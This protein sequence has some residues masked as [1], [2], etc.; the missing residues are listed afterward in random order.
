[1]SHAVIADPYAGVGMGVSSVDDTFENEDPLSLKIYL[2]YRIIP[3]IAVEA[4]YTMYASDSYLDSTAHT[5]ENELEGFNV[6]AL[7]ILPLGIVDVY[8]KIGIVRW[9]YATYYHTHIT[10]EDDGYS[11]LAGVGLSLNLTDRFSLR[12]DIEGMFHDTIKSDNRLLTTA[13]IG[14]TWGF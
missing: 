14:F 4:G 3:F 11:P 8:G 10:Y 9:E 7:G 5:V 13:T 12:A 1:M 2:G 6:S